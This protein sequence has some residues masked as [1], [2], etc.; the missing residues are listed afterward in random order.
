M[1]AIANHK[2]GSEPLSKYVL[3]K[4][5]NNAKANEDEDC[6]L[7]AI[8]A[9][10]KVTVFKDFCDFKLKQTGTKNVI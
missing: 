8:N 1:L 6:M 4:H 10:F 9:Y 5:R 2:N 3:D 7:L